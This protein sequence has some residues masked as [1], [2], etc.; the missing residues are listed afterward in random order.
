M[1]KLE[2]VRYQVDYLLDKAL[3]VFDKA[4]LKI[5][6]D[7]LDFRPTPENM[8]AR[9]LAHHVYQVLYLLT[10]TTEIGAFQLDDLDRIPFDLDRV[11]HPAQIVEY[12]QA[13]KDYARDA[14]VGFTE[15]HLDRTVREGRH[16]TGFDNMTLL[17]EEALHHRGQLMTY[18]R[19]MGV[20]PPFL[21]DY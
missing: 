10:R 2:I 6:P 14:V 15:A 21:Y 16:P 9:A 8:S 13:V 17:F 18:L 11:D 12:G 1:H 19:L 3:V 20:K 7:H 5:P 4:I